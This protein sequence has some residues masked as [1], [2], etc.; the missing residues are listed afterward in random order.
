MKLDTGLIETEQAIF[1]TVFISVMQV[2]KYKIYNMF[3]ILG[4]KFL[5]EWFENQASHRHNVSDGRVLQSVRT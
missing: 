4:Q 1:F 2:L 5:P 3:I